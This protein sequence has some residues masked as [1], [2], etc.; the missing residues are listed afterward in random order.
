MFDEP[1]T[2]DYRSVA[3]G[4]LIERMTALEAAQVRLDAARMAV[5]AELDARQLHAADGATSAAAWLRQRFG[6]AGATGR[7]QVRVA[8]RLRSMPATATAFA[9]GELSYAKVRSLAGARTERTAEAFDRD[10]GLLVDLA[11]RFGCDD[12]QRIVAHWKAS[13]DPDG[14]SAD[15][16]A[17][18][19]RRNASLIQGFDGTWSLHGTLDAGS[20]AVIDAVW[21]SIVDEQRRSDAADPAAPARTAAQRSADALVEV[22]RRAGACDLTGWRPSKPQVSVLVDHDTLL[23][24]TGGEA[25]LLDG[26]VLAGDAARRLA[27][28]AGLSRVVTAGESE[29]LDLGRTTPIPSRA[30]RRVLELR[31]G[32]CIWP[33]CD[34]PPPWCDAHH[35][36]PHRRGS[37]DG[38]PTDLD[39]LGLLCRRH[40]HLVHDEHFGLARDP[41]TGIATVT[42]PDGTTVASAVPTGPVLRR[43]VLTHAPPRRGRLRRHGADQRR[44][45]ARRAQVRRRR[46]RAKSALSTTTWA[47]AIGSTSLR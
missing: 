23:A 27:C 15:R 43:R 25:E 37:P 17:Q 6:T 41:E 7:E 26:T 10:E 36:I 31:D 44:A 35:L 4:E 20:G 14:V 34:R 16:A 40:H 29:I 13:A 5:L 33:A 30:Q 47:R 32:G 3:D 24:E 46:G 42:R 18:W 38:G 8:R 45:K 1:L 9:A 2:F 28:D 21:Q 12:L 39:H 19:S 22:A 11:R